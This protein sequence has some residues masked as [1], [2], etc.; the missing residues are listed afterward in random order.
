[1]KDKKNEVEISV[2]DTGVGIAEKDLPKVFSKFQ[3]FSRKPGPGSKGTGLG[4]A[5][6]KQL[7]EIHKGSVKVESK[8]DKG[9]KFTFRI[10][11]LD[12]DEIFSEYI[13]SGI[14]EV[15]D[16]KA[17]LSLLVLHVD[18]FKSLL[19][20]LGYDKAH[21]LLKE[22][23]GI[24]KECLRRQADTVVRN[25]GELIVLL[26]DTKKKDVEI[27]RERVEKLIVN[28]ISKA[29]E[30]YIKKLHIAFGNAT[31]P[32]DAGDSVELLKKARIEIHSGA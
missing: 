7:V 21:G 12:V 29:K 30:N 4:L 24:V 3:Q 22:I 23:E 27:V 6:V 26:P 2:S 10:P 9:S 20:K 5:I 16:R 18:K 25:T 31:Y 17:T 15:A 13:S 32:D 1:M 28:Y 11:K 8:I 19:N 14:K